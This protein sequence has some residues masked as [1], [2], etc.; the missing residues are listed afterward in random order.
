MGEYHGVAAIS[1][2]GTQVAFGTGG[3]GGQ[4]L[5]LDVQ[6]MKMQHYV[7]TGIA[8][9]A[10]AWL[11]PRRIVASMQCN[12]RNVAGRGCGI[13]MVDSTTG[14]VVRR[15][16]E[17]EADTETLPFEPGFQSPKPFA[18]TP[19]GIVFLLASAQ[20]VAPARLVVIGRD[21]ELRSVTLPS[22]AAGRERRPF[23]EQSAGLA[24]S[25]AGDRAY[26]V[27]LDSIVTEVDLETL[28]IRDHPVQGLD[29]GAPFTTRRAFWLSG[30]IVVHGGGY[31]GSLGEA[32]SGSEP[33][34]VMTIDATS[35]RARTID[36]EAHQAAEAAG[37][38]LVYGGRTLGLAA[39]SADGAQRFHLF[40]GDD[41]PIASV[42]VDGTYAYAVS[43]DPQP[44][45]TVGRARQSHV[46]V[47]DVATGQVI[48]EA[49][50]SAR[51]VDFARPYR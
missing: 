19:Y 7:H 4:V 17:T 47:V 5:I 33:A 26:V 12:P 32:A 21:E 44:G 35:W 49:R 46:R 41:R 16:P 34:G 20:R 38:M 8:V 6:R 15:W 39:Y 3:P 18:T 43:V 36:A 13:A 1:P 28:E 23:R 50:P 51:L 2:D 48:R 9:E 29:P 14:E 10:L 24:I 37:R 40:A 45:E 22:I 11:G 27:G 42:Y 25:P 31:T 30:R